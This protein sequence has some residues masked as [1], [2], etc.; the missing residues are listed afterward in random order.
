M[1][2]AVSELNADR[3]PGRHAERPRTAD[4]SE[5]VRILLAER[6]RLLQIAAGMGLAPAA[7]EDALQDVSVKTLEKAP[8][9]VSDQDC[10]RWLVKVIVN[11]CLIE[12]RRR[13]TFLSRATRILKRHSRRSQPAAASDVATAEELNLV[14]QGLADLDETLLAPLVLRYFDNL[15]S[16]EIGRVLDLKPATVRGRLHR[17]RLTLAHTLTKKG[18][19]P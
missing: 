8:S 11:R 6:A 13:R 9:F 15:D 19:E 7:A 2:L 18:I 4:C 3:T 10:V 16:A 1:G 5:P 12:H 14:R 17:A